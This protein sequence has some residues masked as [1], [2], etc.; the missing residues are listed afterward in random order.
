MTA[1]CDFSR[2]TDKRVGIST[3]FNIELEYVAGSRTKNL[4][5][6]RKTI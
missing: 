2:N 3:R 6:F 4:I 1:L 5:F